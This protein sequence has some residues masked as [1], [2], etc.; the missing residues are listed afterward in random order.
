MVKCPGVIGWKANAHP[1]G[2]TV[3]EN[4]LLLPGGGGGGG[5]ARL[6]LTD[7]LVI[8][9]WSA[10]KKNINA[11]FLQYLIFFL[12]QSDNSQTKGKPQPL[13]LLPPMISISLVLQEKEDCYASFPFT[14]PNESKDNW[15]QLTWNLHSQ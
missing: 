3:W 12:I 5:W 1:P 11:T 14:S 10:K 6:E 2:W 8:S 7:A 4:A 13:Q 9:F 15:V